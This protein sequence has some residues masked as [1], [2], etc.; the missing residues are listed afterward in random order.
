M[1]L[2]QGQTS[3]LPQQLALAAM[4]ALGEECPELYHKESKRL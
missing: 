4:G 1:H 2:A 3:R